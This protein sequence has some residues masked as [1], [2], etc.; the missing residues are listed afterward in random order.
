MDTE[1]LVIKARQGNDNAFYELIKQRKEMLYRT[2]YAYV[3][4]R[5]DALDIV[6]DTVYKAYKNLRKLKEPAFFHTWLTR[7][8]I[9]CSLD[10]LKKQKRVVLLEEIAEAV[11]EIRDHSQ[12]L[13]LYSAVDKL[14]DKCRTAIILKY[15]HDLTIREVAEVMEC[16]QG[17]IKTYLHR[18][19]ASLRL[20]LKEEWLNA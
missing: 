11:E 16:P 8:L 20:D 9:N 10:F 2:A 19:L 12:S 14:E 6:S 1:S 15:F 13:D 5:E 3:K 17:T 18:G 7:I 4:N